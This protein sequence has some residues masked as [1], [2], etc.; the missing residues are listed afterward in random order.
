MPADNPWRPRG[1]SNYSPSPN[2]QRRRPE[3]QPL[4][5][6]Q[7]LLAKNN[8]IDSI[9]ALGDLPKG[10]RLRHADLSSNSIPAVEAPQ[11]THA[12]R[13]MKTLNLASNQLEYFEEDAALALTSLERLDV[14]GT[15][16]DV[17][18]CGYSMQYVTARDNLRNKAEPVLSNTGGLLD[19]AE[20]Q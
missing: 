3:R 7:V 6:T 14:S 9:E 17:R 11:S 8:Q 13:H 15:F 16:Q 19:T 20:E 4:K 12:F 10:V 18:A 1:S 5:H 2:D